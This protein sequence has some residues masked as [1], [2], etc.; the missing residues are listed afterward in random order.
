MVKYINTVQSAAK[1]D[2]GSNKK[3]VK[4]RNELMQIMVISKKWSKM[5]KYINTVKSAAKYDKG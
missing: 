4:P 3:E 2:K 1:H 5:V